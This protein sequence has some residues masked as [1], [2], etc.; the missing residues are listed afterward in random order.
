M[1]SRLTM[2]LIQDTSSGVASYYSSRIARDHGGGI[3]WSPDREEAHTFSSRELA[4]SFAE[5]RLPTLQVN[6]VPW[7]RNPG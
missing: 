7:E 3:G 5:M 6:I 4:L 2:W 1:T